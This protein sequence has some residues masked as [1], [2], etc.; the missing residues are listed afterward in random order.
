MEINKDER[1]HSNETN[2][3]ANNE[4]IIIKANSCVIT[5]EGAYNHVDISEL[6]SPFIVYNN[7]DYNNQV[8]IV[9]TSEEKKEKKM[10]SKWKVWQVIVWAVFWACVGSVFWD[11]MSWLINQWPY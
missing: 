4:T 8:D 5:I 2:I 6:T 9:N 11:S 7:K 10:F 1:L 3:N